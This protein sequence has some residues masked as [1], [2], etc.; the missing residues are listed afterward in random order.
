MRKF[1]VALTLFE[2]REQYACYGRT[3][4]RGKKQQKLDI[5]YF[6]K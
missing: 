5:G 2:Q 3:K 1:G 6:D 4:K